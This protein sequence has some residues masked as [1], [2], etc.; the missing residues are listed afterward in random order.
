MN[1]VNTHKPST[2][3]RQ[4][5]T[6]AEHLAKSDPSNAGWQRDLCQSFT[7]RSATSSLNK[8][9][10]PKLSTPTGTA[11]RSPSVW[12]SPIPATGLWQ[13]DLSQ[14]YGKLG[15]AYAAQK[16]DAKAREAFETGRAIIARQVALLP[17]NVK[18]KGLLD[19]FDTHL[20]ALKP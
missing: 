13:R 9:S 2:P 11:S 12:L 1:K 14:S 10:S 5:L 18:R 8:A 16:D 6:V 4:D 20:A 19:W 17:E 7:K 3:T 15:A